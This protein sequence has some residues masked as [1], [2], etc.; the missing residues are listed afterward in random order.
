MAAELAVVDR[1]EILP[2][3]IIGGE[4]V[5]FLNSQ[6]GRHV[7]VAARAAAQAEHCEKGYDQFFHVFRY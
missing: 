4:D 1:L 3:I 6:I 7:E 5:L 2:R